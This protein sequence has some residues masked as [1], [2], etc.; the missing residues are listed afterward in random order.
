[1]KATA[2][3]RVLRAIFF[4]HVLFGYNLD[5][6]YPEVTSAKRAEAANCLHLCMDPERNADHKWVRE[7]VIAS[8]GLS[9]RGG[10]YT[11]FRPPFL[12]RHLQL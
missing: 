10:L 3:V 5:G 11:I 7:T 4:S 6:R 2:R 9:G 1:M 8:D 12:F